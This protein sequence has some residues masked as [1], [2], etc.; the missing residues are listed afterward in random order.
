MS[1]SQAC[2]WHGTFS[3]GRTI[4]EG[5][6]LAGERQQRGQVTTGY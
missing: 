6:Q 3:A 4:V 5:E 1:R 2:Y